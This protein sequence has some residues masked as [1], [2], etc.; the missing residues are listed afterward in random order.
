MKFQPHGFATPLSFRQILLF[1]VFPFVSTVFAQ[2]MALNGDLYI[3]PKGQMH[4]AVPKTLFLSG[5]VLADRGTG[6]DYGV[7][8]FGAN[9]TTERADHN[10]HVNGFVRSHNRENFIYPIGHRNILQPVHFKSDATDAVLDFAYS[11]VPH[12]QSEVERD[13]DVISDEFYWSIRG[14]G[15]SKIYLSWNTFSNLDK[16]TDNQLENLTI[17]AFDGSV[18]KKIDAQ[19]DEVHFQDGS[20]PTLLSGSISSIDKIDPRLYSAITL[21]RIKDRAGIYDFEVSEAITPN[22]DGINDTWFVEDILDHP[23]ST[24]K[25]FNRLGQI[26]FQAKNYQN[27]WRGNYKDNTD[28]LPESS[29]YYTIDLEGDG[30]VDKTGWIY[31]TK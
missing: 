29:Y 7:M 25:V 27:D 5:E 15:V 13:L 28:T 3:S 21:A 8:S 10:S 20:R 2:Q 23:N 31:I 18:W 4:V 1:I 9:S 16:L 22:G 24:V 19:V 11:H 14:K 26:V 30:I 12:A 6:T 17:A